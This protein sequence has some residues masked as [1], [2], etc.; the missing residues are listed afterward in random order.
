MVD[1]GKRT[2][3][4]SHI[5]PRW[6][7]PWI[8]DLHVAV[9]KLTAGRVGSTLVGRPGLLL[10]TI[11]RKS[12]KP[13]TVFLPY[14]PD[15]ETMVVTASFAGSEHHPDWYHNLQANPEVIVRDRDRVF[16]CTSETITG[17]E[18]ELLWSMLVAGVPVY[19]EYQERCSREI[20]LV[21]LRYSRP[22]TG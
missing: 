11:G 12:G 15:G 21:R 18:R 8:S 6:L 7:I 5:T 2:T 19:A 20:P 16:W 22:Y 17:K 9:Y 4:L 1:K 10:R 3:D 14:V 13:H